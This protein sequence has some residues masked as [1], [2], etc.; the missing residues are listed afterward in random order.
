MIEIRKGTESDLTSCMALI[1]ELAVYEKEPDAVTVTEDQFMAFFSE[2]RFEL[3]V[4]S[5]DDAV[6]GMALFYEAYSTWKGKYLYL[7]D[8]VVTASARGR[9]IGS[10]IFNH[11]LQVVADRDMALLKWQVLD[12]NSPAIKFYDRYPITKDAAWIDCK[13]TPDHS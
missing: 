9:G 10:M 13:Y 12:W 2:G 11:L 3:I 8:F 6:L 5:E 1:K 4:A 7:D